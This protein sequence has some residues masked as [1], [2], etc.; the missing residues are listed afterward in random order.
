[1]FYPDFFLS[2]HR[3]Y[4]HPIACVFIACSAIAPDAYVLIYTE[5]TI[6]MEERIVTLATDHYTAAEVLKARLESAGIDVFLKHINLLQGAVSEGVQIQIRESD[7]EK[8]LRLM[9]VWKHEQEDIDQTR[10][11]NIRRILV[12]VDFSA[13]SKNACLFALNLARKYDAELKILHVYYAPIVDLVPI[14]DAYSIQ[15][16][17]DINL[18][19]LES[20]AKKSLLVFVNDIRAFARAQ[21]IENVK[22]G[23]SLREGITEDEIAISAREYKPGIIVVGAKGKGDKQ[24]DIF[25]DVVQRVLDKIQ[26]PVLA[27]PEHAVLGAD[28]D[29]K[30]IIYVTDFDESDYVALR[31]LMAILDTFNVQIH[32]V[33]VSKDIHRTWSKVKM[34]ELKA[35]FG[36]IHPG[37]KIYCHLL[38][39]E[40]TI[41]AL[42]AFVRTHKI[43]LFSL[44]NRKRSVI[45]RLFNPALTKKLIN[46]LHIPML[47]FRA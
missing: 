29:V 4:F 25:G 7:V 30:N 27:I 45:F 36:R 24:N 13:C 43:D 21:G 26:I 40:D 44:I 35:Y 5:K 20:A 47:V 11:K 28:A 46:H 42:D 39:G 15:I 38:E 31:R 9:S 3:I 41:T 10:P 2:F 12:P 8:A 14:T 18:R 6:A 16:D 23:Y 32:C 17:M 33:H 22:I 34:D 19:E 1:M 37:T